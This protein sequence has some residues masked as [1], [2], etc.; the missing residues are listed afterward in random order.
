MFSALPPHAHIHTN[1]TP[2]HPSPL[3]SSPLRNSPSPLKERDVN[4]ISPSSPIHYEQDYKMTSPTPNPKSSN[5]IAITNITPVHNKSASLPSPP[6]SRG[7]FSK[8]TTKVNPL[9]HGRD[10]GRETRRKLFLKRVR[11]EGEEKR[12][13]GRERSV[14]GEGEEEMEMMRCVWIAEERRR[15]REAEAL[16]F[17]GEEYEL[18]LGE[19][20][21]DLMGVGRA[22][23]NR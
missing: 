11:E 1:Y 17:S 20:G 22:N 23:D 19:F 5:A 7:G 3:S 10:D 14:N 8:R 4:A 13:K 6:P 21:Y 9:I 12:W 15:K 16:G 2:Y 18:S